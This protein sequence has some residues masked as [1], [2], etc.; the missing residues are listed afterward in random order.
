MGLVKIMPDP[1]AFW[2]NQEGF[3]PE[4]TSLIL[5]MWDSGFLMHTV[6]VTHLVAGVLIIVNNQN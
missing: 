5:A 3:S 1:H 6:A 2:E 4:A